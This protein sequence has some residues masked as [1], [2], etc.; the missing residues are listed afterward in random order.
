MIIDKRG[1]TL[2]C[3]LV[4]IDHN[5]WLQPSRNNMIRLDKFTMDDLVQTFMQTKGHGWKVVHWWRPWFNIFEVFKATTSY[6][7]WS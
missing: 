7:D 5:K 1:E 6:G 3:N 4:E 2:T